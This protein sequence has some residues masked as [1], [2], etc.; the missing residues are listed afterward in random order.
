MY[1]S[2]FMPEDSLT[3]HLHHHGQTRKRAS[4]NSWHSSSTQR[5]TAW[6]NPKL[7]V[8]QNILARLSRHRGRTGK[9]QARCRTKRNNQHPVRTQQTN[10]ADTLTYSLLGKPTASQPGRLN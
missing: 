4:F 9:V 8:Q 5:A 7:D 10:T 2:F 1:F 6:E 3:H